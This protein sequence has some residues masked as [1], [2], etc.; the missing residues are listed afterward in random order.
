MSV[1]FTN[2]FSNKTDRSSITKQ[3]RYPSINASVGIIESLTIV[4]A[5]TD[6][7]IGPLN[8]QDTVYLSSGITIRANVSGNVNSVYFVV[9]RPDGTGAGSIESKAP[10]SLG[11]D[12]NGDYDSWNFL[13]PKV[14]TVTA[15]P[16]S[17]KSMGGEQGP[18]VTVQFTT[19]KD[20]AKGAVVS[21]TLINANSDLD[22]RTLNLIDTIYTSP[23]VNVRV[24]VSPNPLVG[25]VEIFYGANFHRIESKAPYSVAGDNNGDYA[26]WNLTPGTYNLTAIPYSD[27]FGNGT[28]GFPLSIQL[29]VIELPVP[30][31]FS[32]TMPEESKDLVY[33]NPAQDKIWVEAEDL[34]GKSLTVQ[35]ISEMGNVI[36]E[37]KLTLKSSP[38]ELNINDLTSG[39]YMIYIYGEGNKRVH[40]FA[41]K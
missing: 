14:Y 6:T 21:F 25:S 33:P 17:E 12:T 10:F 11:G 1:L 36:M 28:Q 16:F 23:D 5:D 9:L 3:T 29:T 40:K 22:I 4:N 32:A 34:T 2:A 15:T 13:S 38:I 8:D 31:R 35:V 30:I 7:D 24:N 41:K 19:I 26:S 39:L 18:T 27:K 37:D 20:S